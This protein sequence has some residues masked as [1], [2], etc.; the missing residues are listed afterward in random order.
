MKHKTN[1][2]C[3]QISIQHCA[4]VGLLLLSITA[5]APTQA[6]PQIAKRALAATVLL[7]VADSTGNPLKLGSG[8]FVDNNLV[9]TNFH[10]IKGAAQG[11]AKLV[12][13]TTKYTIEGFTASD[14]KNDL[15]IL[16]VTPIAS[17]PPL[18]IQPLSLGDSDTVEIG[19]T[20]YVAGN[21]EGLEGT[22]TKGVI[23]RVQGSTRFQMDAAISPGSSGGPVLNGKSEVIGV[24]V[25]SIASR[26]GGQNLNFSVTSNHLKALLKQAGPVKPLSSQENLSI[27]AA[28]YYEW[29]NKKMTHK[30]YNA[31]IEDYNQAIQKY[32]Y[33]YQDD[34]DSFFHKL[35]EA[36]YVRG[37]AKYFLAQYEEAIEDYNQAIRIYEQASRS[38]LNPDST[39]VSRMAYVSYL[40]GRAKYFL[41]QYE[42]AIEDYNQT[43]KRAPNFIGAYHARGRAKYFLAQYEEAIE[44]YNQTI[45][46]QEEHYQKNSTAIEAYK[47]G[48][49]IAEKY[50]YP[51]YSRGRAKYSLAQ[52]EEAIEDYN[53]TIKRNSNFAEAYYS[54]GN[55]KYS[56][57]QYEEAIEDYNKAIE[58]NPMFIKAYHGRYA[59]KLRLGNWDVF[60][61]SDLSDSFRS[62]ESLEFI[63]PPLPPE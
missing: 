47:T 32:D 56:L 42:E 21:P 25:A 40:R 43:I 39:I 23:S 57:A 61:S 13:N 24:S 7:E 27:A 45:K 63:F 34:S 36:Y 33:F 62:L 60:D 5:C 14:D 8:F 53:Q 38:N 54:R 22:F 9:A 1:R 48:Q 6:D 37:T 58:L 59:A 31:A 16:K 26:E 55:A 46:R 3:P 29:A 50:S 17:Q 52:Y 11:T 51:Y 19:E 12:G 10:V 18:D 4:V 44:D 2:E 41:A 30:E 35:A 28:T 15:A 49:L 20:V